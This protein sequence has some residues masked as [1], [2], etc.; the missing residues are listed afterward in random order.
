VSRSEFKQ[1]EFVLTSALE[2]P[3]K[4]VENHRAVLKQLEEEAKKKKKK[5]K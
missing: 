1:D 3:A 5:K 2:S 4:G